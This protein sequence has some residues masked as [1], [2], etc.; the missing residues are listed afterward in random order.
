MQNIKSTVYDVFWVRAVPQ[1]PAERFAFSDYG[2]TSCFLFIYIY[3]IVR[4]T[5]IVN[6]FTY[7]GM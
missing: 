1:A 5:R 2:F 4:A 6:F 3:V 7:L